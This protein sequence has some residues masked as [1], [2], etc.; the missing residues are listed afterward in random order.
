MID[1]LPAM[2]F[3]PADYISGT[4]TLTMQQRGIYC[5][6]LFFSHTYNGKGLPNNIDEL[7]RMIFPMTFNQ[8]EIEKLRSD[9][10]LVLEQK[11]FVEND[12]YFNKRQQIEFVR[13][14]ELSNKRSEARKKKKF[15]SV[16]SNQLGVISDNDN[17]IDIDK[18][19]NNN[20]WAK[21]KVKRGSKKLAFDKWVKIKDSVKNDLLVDKF[22]NLCQQTSD[23]I[24]V[25]HFATWLN[26]QRWKDEEVF[27]IE[28]F[29]KEHNIDFNF[30]EEKD[31]LL[32]FT[33]KEAWGIMDWVYD[34]QGN[35]IKSS[36]L[37]GKEEKETEKTEA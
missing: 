37:N 5:D 10:T 21:L 30:I 25:P 33:S 15:D 6:L 35:S 1:K 18:E 13:G 3:F 20:I 19:F 28:N 27:S 4:R 12:R 22:N 24:Y 8:E 32:Y 26:Q 16:L 17:D 36:E 7:C 34:K 11:F 23:D 31:N 14:L 2:Y 29:K 9:L